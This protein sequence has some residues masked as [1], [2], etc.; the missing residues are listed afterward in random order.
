MMT[1]PRDPAIAPG[2]RDTIVVAVIVAFAVLPIPDERFRVQGLLL[3]PALLPA[4]VLP[5]RRRRPMVALAVSVLCA[6]IIAAGGII[7]PSALLA[8]AVSAFAVVDRRGRLVGVIAVASGAVVA[9]LSN[10]LAMRG[11]LFDSTALQFVVLI[12]LGGAL[13]DAARSRR[14][15]LGAITE[16]AERAEEGRE[17]EARRRVAEERVRIARDLHDVVAHQIAVISLNAG[18]ASS[19]LEHRPERAREALTTI[20]SASRTVLTDIGGLMVILRSDDID[21]VRSL[22]PQ[23]GLAD[24]DALVARFTAAGLRI[25]L[26]RDVPASSLSPASDHVAYLTIHEGLTNAHKHGADGVVAVSMRDEGD[27]LAV[28]LSNARR[29]GSSDS[30]LSGHGLRGLRERVSAVRGDV[31]TDGTG[32]RFILSVRIPSGG[33]V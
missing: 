14:E 22:Q 7:A 21:D 3:I 8:A 15:V 30:T 25:D 16:R 12:V 1:A 28:M 29:P 11:E 32:D 18:V 24:L 10:G 26:E 33:D 23:S 5:F 9:Y 17:G 4:V 13:G 20:R 31:S 2:V 6:V 27:A 19:A